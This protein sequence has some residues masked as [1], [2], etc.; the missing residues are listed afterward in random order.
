M[1]LYY[2]R[3]VIMNE[4]ARRHVEHAIASL[5]DVKNC[6][7]KASSNAENGTMRERI[8]SQLSS[9]ENCIDECD[10]ICSGLSNLAQK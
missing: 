4:E 10:G 1:L 6:L 8:E 2:S 5:K 7:G 3:R 9:I